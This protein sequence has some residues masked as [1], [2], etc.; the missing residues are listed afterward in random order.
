MAD[1]A[2]IRKLESILN[3]KLKQIDNHKQTR[4]KNDDAVQELRQLLDDERRKSMVDE[5]RVK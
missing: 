5:G 2:T 4:S 1:E 3:E